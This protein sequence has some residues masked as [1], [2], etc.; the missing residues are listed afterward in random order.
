[1]R[2][3]G[4]NFSSVLVYGLQVMVLKASTPEQGSL[5]TG[6]GEQYG[7]QVSYPDQVHSRQELNP[8]FYLSSS[9]LGNLKKNHRDSDAFMFNNFLERLEQ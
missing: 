8:L 5:L 2:I 7:C 4:G 6:L 9:H 1:M 3:I